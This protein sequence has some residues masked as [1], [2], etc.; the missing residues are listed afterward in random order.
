MITIGSG[1]AL[2]SNSNEIFIYIAGVAQ[3]SQWTRVSG[4]SKPP[5]TLGK[6]V[7]KEQGRTEVRSECKYVNR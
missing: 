3:H 5:V 1:N 2:C 6:S 7:S 4:Q